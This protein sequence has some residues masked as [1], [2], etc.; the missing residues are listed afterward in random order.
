MPFSFT[1]HL[2]APSPHTPLPT[3]QQ[4]RGLVYELLRVGDP[5]VAE[6]V[7]ALSEHKPFTVSPLRRAKV[8]DGASR[9]RRSL[10]VA[11]LTTDVAVALLRG[12]AAAQGRIEIQFRVAPAQGID[13]FGL[14]AHSALA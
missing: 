13:Q 12:V 11:A 5:A 3:G 4:V 14:F 10:R 2:I 7:H 1:L 9:L 8:D 6:A